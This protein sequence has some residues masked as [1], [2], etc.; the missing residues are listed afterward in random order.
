MGRH[1]EASPRARKI[2]ALR[3]GGDNGSR[4]RAWVDEKAGLTL[5][6][7]LGMS[8]PEDERGQGFFRV[9]HMG[10]VNAQMIMGLL[11]GIEA[12]FAALD[13]PHGA[14]ALSAAARELAQV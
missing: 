11:G 1:P 13:I 4:L 6:I 8:E 7:G 3:I 10:H 9:G 12:A 2:T 5:G 14:G